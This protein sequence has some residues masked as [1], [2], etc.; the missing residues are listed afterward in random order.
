M[1]QK[2]EDHYM[3]GVG[4]R[5]ISVLRTSSAPFGRGR[6]APLGPGLYANW[7]MSGILIFEFLG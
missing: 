1:I 3:V 2:C 7:E 5:V 6:P 4:L